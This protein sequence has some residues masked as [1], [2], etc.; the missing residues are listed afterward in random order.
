MH[1]CSPAGRQA[2]A[3]LRSDAFNIKAFYQSIPTDT[4][5]P[6]TVKPL[7]LRSSAVS[8]SVGDHSPQT[9]RNKT[10]ECCPGPRDTVQGLGP[11]IPK[12]YKGKCLGMRHDSQHLPHAADK[13]FIFSLS[14]IEC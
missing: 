5:P 11:I 8:A 10:Q 2:T 4:P 12:G 6:P 13:L 7:D 1:Q 14:P 3:T 9:G